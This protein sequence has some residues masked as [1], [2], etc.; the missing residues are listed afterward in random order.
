MPDRGS[1]YMLVEWMSMNEWMDIWM[2]YF[3]W[4]RSKVVLSTPCS[5]SFFKSG[6]MKATCTSM[7]EESIITEMQNNPSTGGKIKEQNVFFYNLIHN[8]LN[9]QGEKHLWL[10]S[11]WQDA[12]QNGYCFLNYFHV[13]RA[14]RSL[15]SFWDELCSNPDFSK[16]Q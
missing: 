1:Q 15:T 10:F 8:R 4:Y 3:L 11:L 5:I 14:W 7:W 9:T 13:W 2:D 16:Q 6:S 12:C